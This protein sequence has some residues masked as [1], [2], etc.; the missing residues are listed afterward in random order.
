MPAKQM[1]SITQVHS[2]IKEHCKETD[3]ISICCVTKGLQHLTYSSVSAALWTLGVEEI[4]LPMKEKGPYG[5]T[6]YM[7]SDTV[8]CVRGH[9]DREAAEPGTKRHRKKKAKKKTNFIFATGSLD[10]LGVESGDRR[11]SPMD[12]SK[13]KKL[14]GRFL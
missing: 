9:E 12:H 5:C 6:E 1:T 7:V 11:F 8:M 14:N 3:I 13:L 4:L 2:W 10:A